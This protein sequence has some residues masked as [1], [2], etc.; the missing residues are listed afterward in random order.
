MKLRK[1]TVC[2]YYV[3]CAFLVNILLQIDIYISTVTDTR[4]NL[5]E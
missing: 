5:V 3:T 4:V 1:F 2:F